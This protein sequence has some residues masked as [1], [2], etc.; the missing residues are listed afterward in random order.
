MNDAMSD[1]QSW[2]PRKEVF[3]RRAAATAAVTFGFLL[4]M[5]LALAFF[6]DLPLLWVIPPALLLTAGFFFDDALRWRASKYD[7]WQIEEGHFL[8]HGLDGT[9]RVPLAEID[10][11]FTRFGGRV[12][13]QLRSG[14]RIAMRYLP[15]PEKAAQAIDAARPT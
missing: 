10:R 15:Y 7:R 12:V 4:V 11:V 6:A 1:G 2:A 8:H 3:I 13:V 14:Q 5:G 9:A